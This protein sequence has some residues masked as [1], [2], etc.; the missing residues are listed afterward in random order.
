FAGKL[1]I[2]DP[3]TTQANP[4]GAG[5]VRT[6]FPANAIPANR[7]S[8]VSAKLMAMIPESN[9]QGAAN[10]FV[11]N[12]KATQR[13]NRV[14]SRGDVNISDRDK[15]FEHFSYATSNILAPG[16]YEAPLVGATSNSVNDAADNAIAAAIGATHLI[17]ASVVNEF[18]TSYT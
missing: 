16:I 6:L 12:P 18:R 7:I 9:L 13:V 5:F 1:P 14:D 11:N 3:A 2:Y 4:S 10:N 17:S 8:P 15:L